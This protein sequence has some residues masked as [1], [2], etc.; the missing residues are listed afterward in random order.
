LGDRWPITFSR[1]LV[2]DFTH[3]LSERPEMNSQDESSRK[4]KPTRKSNKMAQKKSKK[5]IKARDLKPTKDAKGGRHGHRGHQST[6][7]S[8]QRDGPGV[9]APG[10]GYGIHM[11]Q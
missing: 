10:G 2:P 6:S 4:A 5:T 3:Y 9:Q 8:N 11:V 7:L 1:N